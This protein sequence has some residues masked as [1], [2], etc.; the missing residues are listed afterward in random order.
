MRLD[1]RF[2]TSGCAV[3]TPQKGWCK[4]NITET[5]CGFYTGL[6]FAIASRKPIASAQRFSSI[7][8]KFGKPDSPAQTYFIDDLLQPNGSWVFK[9]YLVLPREIAGIRRKKRGRRACGSAES[10]LLIVYWSH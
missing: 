10:G 5:Q 4:P 7:G 8:G 9:Q 2:G 1:I 3:F 6:E